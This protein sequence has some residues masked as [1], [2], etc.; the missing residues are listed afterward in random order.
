MFPGSCYPI[1][2]KDWR[3]WRRRWRRCLSN[4]N[5]V[6]A[7]TLQEKIGNLQLETLKVFFFFFFFFFFFLNI[8]YLFCQFRLNLYILN[9]IYF[10]H[11][12]WLNYIYIYIYIIFFFF[13]LFFFFF[14]KCHL[15]SE[16]RLKYIYIYIFFST[17]LQKSFTLVFM[18]NVLLI[19]FLSFILFL[20]QEARY[21]DMLSNKIFLFIMVFD[22]GY[23]HYHHQICL[24]L[25]I[26]EYF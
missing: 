13:F 12:F 1:R 15:Y 5:I 8:I 10:F 25:F 6:L 2:Q 26:N 14:F 16:F 3:R 23:P 4:R 20:K 22:K 17:F 24:I 21:L 18:I 9:I 11:E 19:S 7:I